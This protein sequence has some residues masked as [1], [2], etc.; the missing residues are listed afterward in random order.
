MRR[1]LI[2]RLGTLILTVSMLYSTGALGSFPFF[3]GL[4]FI[5]PEVSFRFLLGQ[6][7]FRILVVAPPAAS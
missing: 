4:F 1:F 6:L 5:L 3:S 7:F 2:Y